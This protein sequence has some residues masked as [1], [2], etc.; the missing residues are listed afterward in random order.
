[1]VPTRRPSAVPKYVEPKDR[2]AT[3]DQDGTLWMEHPLC[4][5][6]M[7]ALERLGKM[8][9]EHPDWKEKEPFKLVLSGDHEAMGKFAESDWREIIARDTYGNDHGSVSRA[10]ERLAGNR[11]SAALQTPLHRSRLSAH[12]GSD[13]VSPR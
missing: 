6:A 4:P 11:Q 10:C 9:L 7:F 13:D 1:M 12:V 8:A 3:F 5:Q 2:I